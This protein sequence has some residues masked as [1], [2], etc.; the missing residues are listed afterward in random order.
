[1]LQLELYI[2]DVEE[3]AKLFTTV[4]DMQ[5]VAAHAGWRQ[6]H[7]PDNFDIML[8]DPRQHPA[9]NSHWPLPVDGTGGI[10]IEIV[11]STTEII[12]KRRAVQALGY[13]CSELRYPPWGSTEFTFQLPEGYLLRIKQPQS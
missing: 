9:E 1:M 8:F 12:E 3:T 6:L 2:G 7:H 5:P 10:G 11:M 4:F 13:A